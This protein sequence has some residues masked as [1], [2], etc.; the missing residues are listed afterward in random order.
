MENQEINLEKVHRLIDSLQSHA[1]NGN[2]QRMLSTAQ[3]IVAELQFLD[4]NK[5]DIAHKHGTVSVVMPFSAGTAGLTAP[6]PSPVPASALPTGDR[7]AVLQPPTVIIEASPTQATDTHSF[8]DIPVPPDPGPASFAEAHPA[9]SAGNA[10]P[11]QKE[12]FP[13]VEEEEATLSPLE[14]PQYPTSTPKA[15]PEIQSQGSAETSAP[16]STSPTPSVPAP[17]TYNNPV[18]KQTGKPEIE[19]EAI[20]AGTEVREPV[21]IAQT[22]ADKKRHLAFIS[23][24]FSTWADYGMAGEAPTLVQNQPLVKERANDLGSDYNSSYQQGAETYR[25]LNEQFGQPQE[26]WAQ[27]M[28]STPIENL[29]SAIGVNDRYLYISELFRGDESMYERSIITLNKFNNFHDAH[30][31]SER[32]LRLKLGWDNENPIA[33][34]FEQLVKRRFM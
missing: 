15:F 14:P 17:A 33:K 34:Q 12:L 27:K 26:E 20:Q 32:E 31:W 6:P 7:A 16:T 19:I 29:S 30:A 1:T 5:K 22:E 13:L 23:D 3:L 4:V 11:A 28:Q 18:Q 21:Q 24:N 10:E 9:A 25:E 8:G 2:T